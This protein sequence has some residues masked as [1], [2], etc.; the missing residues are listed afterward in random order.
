ME[1]VC[2]S[3]IPLA[4]PS[5]TIAEDKLTRK[6]SRLSGAIIPLVIGVLL[7]VLAAVVVGVRYETACVISAE[8]PQ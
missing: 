3:W 7:G 1:A 8:R 5:V 2:V 6:R 4:L